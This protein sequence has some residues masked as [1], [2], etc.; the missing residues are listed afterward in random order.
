MTSSVDDKF[1]ST[2]KFS[3]NNYEEAVLEF[4]KLIDALELMAGRNKVGYLLSDDLVAAHLAEPGVPDFER[5]FNPDGSEN[6]VA[7]T[8]NKI[9]LQNYEAEMTLWRKK[10]DVHDQEWATLQTCLGS[11]LVPQSNAH[12]LYKSA[13]LNIVKFKDQYKAQWKALCKWE[14]KLSSDVDTLVEKLKS[15]DDS[16]GWGKFEGEWNDVI[17]KLKAIT[18]EDKVAI[19]EDVNEIFARAITN[20]NMRVMVIKDFY[21]G[22]ED[23]N[24]WEKMMGRISRLIRKN[25]DWD[26]LPKSGYS[27]KVSAMSTSIGS[28]YL[29]K[30]SSQNGHCFMCGSTEH[31]CNHC[32]ASKCET[33]GILFGGADDRK[34]H[35]NNCPNRADS[36][37]IKRT[38]FLEGPFKKKS[39]KP[40]GMKSNSH[41]N[42]SKKSR[43]GGGASEGGSGRTVF[44][45][46][47]K[48]AKVIAQALQAI[49]KPKSGSP[50]QGQA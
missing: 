45:V 3:G 22:K 34:N 39:E 21:E 43:H 1:Q 30:R 26:T 4:P 24:T 5:E 13:K 6:F 2:F 20:T 15:L 23:T 33:C 36:D 16:S 27:V 7:K 46:S 17:G 47:A 14:P 41:G 42:P 31:H 50:G 44:T 40:S 49:Q 10:R 8:L 28:G 29:G 9:K 19:P 32:N 12:T 35:I 37:E 18:I 11:L 25:K 38:K 48:N